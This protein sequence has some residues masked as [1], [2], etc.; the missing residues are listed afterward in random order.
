VTH[1]RSLRDLFK[2]PRVLQAPGVYDGLSALLVERAGFEVAFLSGA[3]L[4]FSRLGRPDLGLVTMTELVQTVRLIRERIEFPLIVDADTGFG[5]ALNVRRTVREL[6]CAGASAVQIEDQVAPKRCGHMK[7]KQVVSCAEMVGKL[8]AALD[9]RCN[10]DTVIIARTD[11]L[12]VEGFEAALERGAAYLDAGASALFIEGPTDC[13]QM[14]RIAEVF[15]SRAPLVHN[16]VEGGHSPVHTAS[17]LQQL[18][19]RVALYPAMLVHLFAKLAPPYLARL[20]REGGS[21]RFREELLDLQDMNG[22]LGTAQM[23]DEARRYA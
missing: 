19:F 23:L 6:E 12:A 21:Y 13:V 7:G 4:S 16:L 15:G 5:N 1:A 10:V 11:A 9:A 2:A 20:A 8:K 14:K 22:L 17:Q 18:G 3:S